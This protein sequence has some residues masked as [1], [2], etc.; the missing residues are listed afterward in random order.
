MTNM[1]R[2]AIKAVLDPDLAAWVRKE[3][4]DQRCSIAQVFRNLV[5]AE[6]KR[7]GKSKS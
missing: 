2:E 4:Q 1:K 7:R 6:I 5:S 3:A